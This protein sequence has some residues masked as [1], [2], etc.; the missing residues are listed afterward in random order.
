MRVNNVA[1]VFK[2]VNSQPLLIMD[3]SKFPRISNFPILVNNMKTR[4][5]KSVTLYLTIN[6]SNFLELTI[7]QE[8]KVLY[9]IKLFSSLKPFCA[10]NHLKYKL[11]TYKNNQN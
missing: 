1:K 7:M 8:E 9:K 3:S 4:R 5:S 2:E 11:K 6:S 10:I